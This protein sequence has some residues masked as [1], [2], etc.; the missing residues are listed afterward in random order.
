MNNVQLIGNLTRDIELNQIQ[1]GMSYAKFTVAVS[2]GKDHTDFINCIAWNNT[3]G[4]MNKY[5]KKG[6]KI[7]VEGRINVRS[8]ENNEGKTVSITEIVANRVEFLTPKEDKADGETEKYRKELT[9]I[10]DGNLPF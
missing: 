9:E 2:S 4:L 8:Y 3:A 10:N 1:N 5:C 6:N 7:A